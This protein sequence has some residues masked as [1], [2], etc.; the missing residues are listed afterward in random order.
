[1]DSRYCGSASLSSV[2][3]F[4]FFLLSS[5]CYFS[6]GIFGS[7]LARCRCVVGSSHRMVKRILGL[8]P[9]RHAKILRLSRNASSPFPIGST[10]KHV[11]PFAL[12]DFFVAF[13]CITMSAPPR[14]GLQS[15]LR[16]RRWLSS[17]FSMP[18]ALCLVMECPQFFVTPVQLGPACE[19]L[20]LTR[21]CCHRDTR[22]ILCHS[23]NRALCWML[24]CCDLR[25]EC[26]E[27]ASED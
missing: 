3:L 1:M 4:L 15:G 2:P 26:Y 14:A 25:V 8:R 7:N 20:R 22:T 13:A 24:G 17:T 5:L 12:L 19:G 9:L 16:D 18:F 6:S 11:L 27:N 23:L 10:W 21:E